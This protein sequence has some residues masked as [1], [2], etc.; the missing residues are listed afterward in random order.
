VVRLPLLLRAQRHSSAL[1]ELHLW[2]HITGLG[3]QTVS[4]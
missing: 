2:Q 1:E 4:L 3:L